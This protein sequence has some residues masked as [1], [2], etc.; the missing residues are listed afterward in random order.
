MQGALNHETFRRLS[1]LKSSDVLRI[2][3][4]SQMLSRPARVDPVQVKTAACKF[5]YSSLRLVGIIKAVI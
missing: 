1:W 4:Q 3:W 5:L 2:K